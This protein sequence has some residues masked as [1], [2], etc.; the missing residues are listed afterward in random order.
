MRSP[1]FQ[2]H[3]MGC[4]NSQDVGSGSSPG[5]G[6]S[7]AGGGGD[8]KQLLDEYK[9]G[10]V[11]GEGAFG[12]V[13]LCTKK[14][15]NQEFA[16]KMID[17]VETPLE[18]I[19]REAAMLDKLKHENVVRL[20]DTYY[21]KVFV[22]MVMDIYKGG[23]MIEGMQAHW[24]SKGMIPTDKLKNIL[25]QMVAGIAFVHSQSVVHRDVKGDN[26]LMDRKNI[27]DP[28]CKIFLSDFGTVVALAET[29]RLNEKC[30]TK[31]YWAPEFFAL[32]YSFKV[33]IW[34]IGVVLY[35]LICGKFPFKGESDVNNKKIRL[36]SNCAAELVELVNKILDKDEK[37]RWTGKEILVHPWIGAAAQD[38]G[39]QQAA[40]LDF[41]PDIMEK[42]PNK[43]IGER[44]RELVERL[45][46]AANKGALSP[47][48]AKLVSPPFAEKVNKDTFDVVDKNKGLTTSWEWWAASKV[49]DAGM[50][51]MEKASPASAEVSGGSLEAIKTLLHDH[52][53]DTAK[54][55]QGSSRS[56]E[57]FVSEVQTGS[58]RLM[59][60]A[61]K[62]KALVRVMDLVLVRLCFGEGGSK[63]FLIRQK[64]SLQSGQVR[65]GRS[66]LPGTKRAAHENSLETAQRVLKERM[67]FS[68]VQIDFKTQNMETFEEEED[69]A[70]YPGVR[71]VY[72]KSIIEAVVSPGTDPKKI[73]ADG[74]GLNTVDAK[75]ISREYQWMAENECTS[76]QIKL[77]VPQQG[78]EVSALVNPPVGFDEEKLIALLQQGGVDTNKFGEA[79]TKT[80]EEFATELTSG[81]AS[82]ENQKEGIMRIV[83]VVAVKLT[84]KGGSI[85]VE[86]SETK[87]GAKKELKR[88]PAVKRRSD[89]N[90][91]LAAQR[92]LTKALAMD[93]NEVTMNPNDV[94]VMTEQKDSPSYPGIKT[95]YRKRIISASMVQP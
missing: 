72:R 52:K 1:I 31:I 57:D 69:S 59:L 34:A 11:L 78:Q 87:D 90:Q 26:Y 29:Q 60:D 17:K 40:A 56:L 79:G 44:R 76:K 21:E 85:L 41:K 89:E 37:K 51:H 66:Q 95:V 63:K 5:S 58:V 43:N 86:A 14:G 15:T 55:G 8:N 93:D 75:S 83:D 68:G 73:G 27:V 20:H 18:D 42:G 35:G 4:T 39:G 65:D 71:T 38:P 53:I 12:V 24:N 77:R 9:L 88:L 70:S 10:K 48:N 64:E 33:D 16:V 22:C 54:F 80:L 19:K 94:L 81:E 61:A 25:K 32:N 6:G 47:D 13:Y 82:L 46:K 67:Q 7:S 2:P 74:S 28:D 49:T 23:D 45:E 84:R 3:K 91:F 30:G 62:H 92:V 36:P 50:L